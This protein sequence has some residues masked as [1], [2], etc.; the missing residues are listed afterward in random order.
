MITLRGVGL[1]L[2]QASVIPLPESVRVLGNL[3]IGPIFVDI[4]V[5]A[6]ILLAVHVLHRR[7]SFGRQINAIGN[8]AEVAA[9]IGLPVGRLV[10]L[11]FVL[12]GFL[13]SIGGIVAL[14]QVGS[15]S[16]YLGSGMEFTAVAVVVVGGV[17][18]FGGRGSIIPGVLLGALTFQL[19]VNGLTQMSANP[20]PSP[21]SRVPRRR[22]TS[23]SG[24][25]GTP[26]TASLCRSGRTTCRRR[27]VSR[28]RPERLAHHSTALRWV[29][30]SS[31]GHL[32]FDGGNTLLDDDFSVDGGAGAGPLRQVSSRARR[33]RSISASRRPR[34]MD[35][36]TLRRRTG[37]RTRRRVHACFE[38]SVRLLPGFSRC[39]LNGDF[40]STSVGGTACLAKPV[41]IRHC[42]ATGLAFNFELIGGDALSAEASSI[43]KPSTWVILPASDGSAERSARPTFSAPRPT[44][45]TAANAKACAPSGADGARR[46]LLYMAVVGA[47]TQHNRVLKAHYQRLLARGKEPK[48]AII[49]C[50]RKLIVILNTMLARDEPWNPPAQA[51]A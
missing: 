28:A 34:T 47:A 39:G 40:R 8:G 4:L 50:M 15:L 21:A 22:R 30:S 29:K 7:T 45:T 18:L 13:A 46:N 16:A 19:I 36:G 24:F 35:Y 10:F 48:V 44:T 49:A 6:A 17:S 33:A 27:A 25:R 11:D 43:P 38:R 3:S 12:A 20:R 51:T 9:R 14:L 2:T 42:S 31:A 5:M 26:R 37:P 41:D 1:E 32:D 23:P